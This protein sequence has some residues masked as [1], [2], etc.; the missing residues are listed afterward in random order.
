MQ[1]PT[2]DVTFAPDHVRKQFVSWDRG[3]PDREWACLTVLAEHAPG[4]APR[5][6]RRGWDGGRPFVVMQRLPGHPLGGAPLSGVQ[7]AGLGRALGRLFAVPATAVG[8]AGLG[9]RILGPATMAKNVSEWLAEP[10]DLRACLDQAHVSFA[11]DAA[12][13]WLA[14]PDAVP[15]PR[16]TALGMADLNPAN[17]MWDGTTCR[18]LDF[19]DGGLSDPAYEMADHIEHIAGRLS[20]VIDGEALLAAVGLPQEERE[21]MR[22][23]RP[24][25]AAFWLA[26]LLPENSGSHRNPA[27]ATEM[28]AT[29]LL[30]L[31]P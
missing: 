19:E 27:G 25:F 18:L 12:L 31:L 21:R 15:Q 24:L 29:H 1:T 20:G 7:M 30:S 2:H 13:S 8:A 14:R 16:L 28:Q 11:I 22:A 6:L 4:L 5:P 23:Y 17:L 9:E 3:E 26:M 10:G